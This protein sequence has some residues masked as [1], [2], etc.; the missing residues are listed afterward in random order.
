MKAMMAVF[1]PI[2]ETMFTVVVSAMFTVML[3]VLSHICG[4]YC[5]RCQ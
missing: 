2:M 1:M 4:A 5:R 3:A